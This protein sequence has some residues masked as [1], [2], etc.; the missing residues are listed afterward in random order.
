M[1]FLPFV[2]IRADRTGGMISLVAR[3]EWAKH[4]ASVVPVHEVLS[5][6]LERSRVNPLY[7]CALVIDVLS[8]VKVGVICKPSESVKQLSL[9]A[10]VQ[11]NAP[12]PYP[13]SW[14]SAVQV[15]SSNSEN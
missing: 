15:V 3:L 11:S 1:L 13:L 5:P 14:T 9:L 7:I 12:L 10:V 6:G 8:F 4:S 2:L